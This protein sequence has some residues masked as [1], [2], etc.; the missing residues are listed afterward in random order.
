M[1]VMDN[2][3]KMISCHSFQLLRYTECSLS[4]LLTNM[5][6]L[7]LHVFAVNLTTIVRYINKLK[8]STKILWTLQGEAVIII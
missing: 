3:E 2:A 7:K 8:Q 4:M 5:F 6:L 1:S